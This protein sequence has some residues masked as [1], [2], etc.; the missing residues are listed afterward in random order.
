MWCGCSD[1][2]TASFIGHLDR[3]RA[4][5]PRL[6]LDHC[7]LASLAKK[8]KKYLQKGPP[9]DVTEEGRQA[10]ETGKS[11]RGKP[12]HVLQVMEEHASNF[13]SACPNGEYQKAAKEQ[14]TWKV[15]RLAGMIGRSFFISDERNSNFARGMRGEWPWHPTSNRALHPSRHCSGYLPI[16]Y[17]GIASSFIHSP[18]FIHHYCTKW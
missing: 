14:R 17:V 15:G 1:I 5:W 16:C 4:A 13:N 6:L 3:N 8:K 10:W 11:E 7:I 2:Q 9:T 12:Q 18:F